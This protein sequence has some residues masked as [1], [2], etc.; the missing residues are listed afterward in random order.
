M[1]LINEM[2]VFV[3]VFIWFFQASI[4][5]AQRCARAAFVPNRGGTIIFSSSIAAYVSAMPGLATYSATKAGQLAFADDLFSELRTSGV[6]VCSILL[7]SVDTA[8]QGSMMSSN[9]NLRTD[10]HLLLQPRDIALTCA[11]VTAHRSAI[12]EIVIQPQAQPMLPL[13][14]FAG[15]LA[16]AHFPECPESL[17][18]DAAEDTLVTR[19]S[20]RKTAIVTGVSM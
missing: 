1:L 17:T 18:P 5:V 13:R 14:R 16:Q 7:G 15:M 19:R 3:N 9:C 12:T 11:F 6:R 8:L 2:S 4:L 20:G 10:R